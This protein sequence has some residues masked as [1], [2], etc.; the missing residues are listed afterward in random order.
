MNI[1]VFLILLMFHGALYAQLP[2]VSS[3][4][5]PNKILI[6][7]EV[8][9][10]YK[11]I[12]T[13]QQRILWPS[14]IDSISV[15]FDVLEILPLDTA[16]LNDSKYEFTQV[17]K[18]TAFDSGLYILP[19]LPFIVGSDTVFS[20]I[21]QVAVDYAMLDSANTIRDIKPPYKA[22][23]NFAELKPYIVGVLIFLLLIALVYFIIKKLKKK[24]E[25]AKDIPKEQAH[26]L[27]LRELDSLSEEK[28]WQKGEVKEYYAR[29]SEIIR[30][31][32][33]NRFDVKALEQVHAEIIQSLRSLNAMDTMLLT[34]L[35][36]LLAESDLVKFA[37]LQPLTDINDRM[38]KIAYGI[39]LQTKKE[40]QLIDERLEKSNVEPQTNVL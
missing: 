21:L 40:L 17:I 18:V 8:V 13:N 26:I 39:V 22:Q 1:N 19:A 30:A 12:A 34:D 35:D 2:T 36:T 27:A 33:E 24:K 25:I 14:I 16:D 28:L 9:V 38:L 20:N 31:Y 4:V 7:Q 11:V 37:K 5:N 23:V 15:N 32:I 3:S 10:S 29:L 6:G